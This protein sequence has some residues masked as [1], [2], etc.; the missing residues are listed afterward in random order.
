MMALERWA[1]WASWAYVIALALLPAHASAA[2]RARGEPIS[3]IVHPENPLSS[4][5]LSE[6]RAILLRQK[7][8]W[9]HGEPIRILNWEAN[10]AVRVALD[11]DVLRMSPDR[12]AAYWIDQRIRG[13][14]TPPRSIS[15]SALIQAIVARNKDFISYVPSREVSPRVKTLAVE[16][17]LPADPHYPIRMGD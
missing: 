17:K 11:Q 12:V 14:G 13:R 15:S 3:V 10:S 8:R 6:L 4:A 2:E 9:P 16:G 7:S 5:S 1:G